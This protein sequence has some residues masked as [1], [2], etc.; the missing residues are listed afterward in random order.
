MFISNFLKGIFDFSEEAKS[1]N[2]LGLTNDI[3]MNEGIPLTFGKITDVNLHVDELKIFK[4]GKPQS[5]EA[6][7]FNALIHDGKALYTNSGFKTLVDTF[8]HSGMPLAPFPIIEHC[9]GLSAK[10]S[11]MAIK[12]GYAVLA[13]DYYVETADDNC[14]FNMGA[15]A[16]SQK[17]KKEVRMIDK[18]LKMVKP[19]VGNAKKM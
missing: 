3:R 10:D 7:Y 1:I 19:N 11:S 18:L 16:G 4:G 5:E 17:A 9:L 12:D 8:Y 14:L 2:T 15:S 6:H 13:F